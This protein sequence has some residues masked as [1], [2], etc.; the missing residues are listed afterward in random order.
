M[1]ALL[2]GLDDRNE[3]MR[4]LM[5]SAGLRLIDVFVQRRQAP[6]PKY[7]VGKGKLED[8]KATVERQ[9]I[10][11]VVFAG[12][13]RPNQHHELEKAL[14]VQCYDRLRVILEIFTRRAQSREARLQV[15]LAMLQY[16]IPI[17]KEW[18]HSAAAGERPGF[19][20]G[21]EYRV[22]AYYETVKRKMK[23]VRDE[24]ERV[25]KERALHVSVAGYANAGKSSLFNVLAGEQVLVED[26]LFTTLSTTTR[27]LEPPARRVLLTDTVGFVSNVP[28]WLVEAFHSTLE[29]V[30]ASDLVLLLVDASDRLEEFRAKVELAADTLIPGMDVGKILPVLTKTDLT[31]PSEVRSRIDILKDSSFTRTPIAV[32][33]LK[34]EGI[35]ELHSILEGEFRLPVEFTIRISQTAENAAFM[36]WIYSETD[37]LSTAYPENT[38]ELRLRCR[39]RDVSRIQAAAKVVSGPSVSTSS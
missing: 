6:D 8:L 18:I 20:A 2:V 38:V 29:E 16:E 12:T 34:K 5:E 10:E 4:A 28:L 9:A 11:I 26:R 36:N 7:F 19:M 13:L 31:P 39:E 21:G 14:K 15:E 32:S 3:E 17:L 25:R 24:L 35:A 22:D 23:K 30:Y 33:V 1:D 37:I 27:I